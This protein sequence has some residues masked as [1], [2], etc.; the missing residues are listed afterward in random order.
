MKDEYAARERFSN[1]T[2][3]SQAVKAMQK[4]G[5][6]GI[7]E[8]SIDQIQQILDRA[9]F[10][11]PLETRTGKKLDTLRGRTIIH[12]FYE[13]STRTRT[14]FEIAAKRLGA[15]TISISADGSSVKK[16]ESLLDTLNTLA[17]M[18]PD[19]IVMRHFS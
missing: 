18:R 4:R 9:K 14:S 5:L 16:G 12:L 11:Q 13:A 6:L 17:A 19:A 7:E 10:Y 1:E 2:G 3:A 15:D 8:L